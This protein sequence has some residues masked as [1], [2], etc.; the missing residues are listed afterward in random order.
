MKEYSDSESLSM[1]SNALILEDFLLLEFA[2]IKGLDEF[3]VVG[4]PVDWT[5]KRG[6]SK[7]VKIIFKKITSFQRK[8]PKIELENR[9]KKTPLSFQ[10][11]S[12]TGTYCAE[13]CKVTPEDSNRYHIEIYLPFLM[14]N[15]AFQFWTVTI[16]EKIVTTVKGEDGEKII[17]D[18]ETG[19]EID[20]LYPF[21]PDSE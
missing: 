4:S 13:G 14:G 15:I 21:G 10:A 2:F 7:F 16:F 11:G 17:Q 5:L 3:V 20:F 19:Q 18:H 9:F 8:F 12:Y 1:I 6:Q